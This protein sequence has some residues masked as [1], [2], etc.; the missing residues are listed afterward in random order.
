MSD[1]NL[2]RLYATDDAAVWAEE[3]AKVEPD[4]DRGLMVGWFANA[5]ET[6]KDLEACEHG[7]TS[8]HYTMPET[9]MDWSQGLGPICDIWDDSVN[10]PPG[11]TQ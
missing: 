9:G 7:R 1:I 3:F 2:E 11:D 10:A 6:A 4:I 8:W 5:I